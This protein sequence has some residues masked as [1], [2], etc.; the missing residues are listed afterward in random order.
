[1]KVKKYIF[2]N[3]NGKYGQQP[4]Y[5]KFNQFI[6]LLTVILVKIKTK[7]NRKKTIYLQN[8]KKNENKVSVQIR[9]IKYLKNKR[10]NN[11]VIHYVY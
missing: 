5:Y 3:K 7:K 11:H 10:N 6:I 9:L 8:L 4:N 2:K 1:M